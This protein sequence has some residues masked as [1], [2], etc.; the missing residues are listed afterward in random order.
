M[1]TKLIAIFALSVLLLITGGT[2]KAN[3]IEDV[4][5]HTDNQ[6]PFPPGP[7]FFPGG[8]TE[9]YLISGPD[10]GWTHTFSFAGPLPPSSIL[11]ATLEIKQFGVLLYDEHEIFFDGESLGFLDNGFPYETT[12]TTVFNLD[13]TAIANIMDETV[14]IWLD[15]DWPNSVAIYWSRLTINYVPAGLDHIVVSGP[16]EVQEDSGA[17]FTCIAHFIDSSTSDV[18]NSASWSDNSSFAEID[19]DGFLTTSLVSSDEP[20]QIKAS[21]GDKTDTYDTTI[22]NVVPIVYITESIPTAAEA[23]LSGILEVG[24][25][26]STKETLRVFYNTFGSTAAPDIDYIALPG[27]V[28]IPAGETAVSITVGPIDDNIEEGPETVRVNIAPIPSE[29]IIDPNLFSATVTIADDEG[30]S[31]EISGR[32]PGI[33]AIQAARDTVI[34]LHVT[35]D[36]SGVDNVTISVNGDIIYDGIADIYDTTGEAQTVKGICRRAGTGLDYMYVF[37]SSSLFDYEQKIDVEVSATDV[38]GHLTTDSYSFFTLMRT[39]GKNFRVNTDPN[40]FEQNNPDTAIDSS[41]NIWVVW[42]QAVTAFDSDIYIGK[43]PS[44]AS[45]FEP[46]QLV[47]GDPNNQTNPAIAIAPDDTIYVTWQGDD[48]NGFWDIFVSTSD[49]G[50]DWDPS[51]KVNSDDPHNKSNQ[52]SPAIAIDSTGLAYISWEDNSKGSSDRD[53][54][55][56]SSSDAVTWFPTLIG[57]ATGNQTEPVIDIVDGFTKIPY[58]FWTDARG[59]NMDIFASKK[60][61][62]WT[63]NPIVTTLSNQSSPAVSITENSVIHL[64][65]V[66]DV[67]GFVGF[68]DI[69]YGNNDLGLPMQGVSIVDEPGTQQKYPSIAANDES[70][71]ACWRDSRNV[72]FNADYDIYYAEKTGAEFGTNIL[73]NDDIGQFTQTAPVINIDKDGNPYLVWVDNREGNNDIYAAGVTSIGDTLR[74]RTVFA[75]SGSTQFVQVNE[76]TE[77]VDDADDVGIEIPVGALPV[78]TTIKI[79]KLNNPPDP[80]AGAFGVFYEF[81]PSGLEFNMP[82]TITIPHN[83]SDCPG[84]AVYA[85]YFYDPTIPPPASPW[86]QEGIT[87]V[88]HI[89]DLEDPNLPPDVHIIRFNSDH[90]TTF[91]AGSGVPSPPG[92]SGGGGGGGGCSVSAGSEGNIV[93]YFLPYIGF[94]IVLVILTLRDARVRKAH[95][96]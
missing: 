81:S 76:T 91:G 7:N 14:D 83:A 85:V 44:G 30:E 80:P 74:S 8:S 94:C 31:P 43:L 47:F 29:Y 67:S 46:S 10:W 23:G 49:D 54:W 84:H 78:D 52:T 6:L 17:Q 75:S 25:V 73:V 59:T 26:G 88:E 45:S 53:I 16:S 37:Q 71:F 79:A 1:R 20:C 86:S 19:S 58:V 89:T 65:W 70:V 5:D 69:F 96:G 38:A 87:N 72:A 77:Q 34:Q 68:E 63:E 11:S 24:R 55:V 39:F 51:V 66:D 42:E 27:F 41:G 33:D 56:A 9:G 90:F 60:F 50:I 92:V 4:K 21:F 48:P 32:M 18:T 12:H 15:I 93:E 82:I 3:Q 62:T 40:G 35:D 2:V 64:L 28:D 13:S 57:S 36:S 61:V 22:K 95:G